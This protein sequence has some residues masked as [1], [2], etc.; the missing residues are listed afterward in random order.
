MMIKKINTNILLIHALFWVVYFCF[1]MYQLTPR[2]NDLGVLGKPKMMLLPPSVINEKPAHAEG[3][4]L[5]KPLHA[6]SFIINIIDVIIHVLMMMILAYGNYSFLLPAYLN[7]K[8]SRIDYF[9]KTFL[10]FVVCIFTLVSIKSLL[11]NEFLD[12]EKSLFF[13][14][15]FIIELSLSALFIVFFVSLLKFLENYVEVEKQKKDIENERLRNEL[16]LL[17]AQVNPHFLF[18]VFNNL[19]ALS[20]ENSKKTPQIIEK[21]AQIMRYTLYESNSENVALEKEVTLIENIIDL[22]QLHLGDATGRIIF[23]K[24]I[25]KEN[26]YKIAPMILITFLEN[27]FKHG[28]KGKATDINISLKIKD[29]TLIYNIINAKDDSFIKV[30]KSGIGLK[31]AQRQLEFFY[32]NQ[33]ILNVNESDANYEVTLT[34]KITSQTP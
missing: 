31:N 22:E 2:N 23:K 14:P 16:A 8:S 5:P 18:N 13:K 10:F 33:Y 32:P 20:L 25:D 30:E 3:L 26:T 27:A 19:Y 34:L 11:R 29:N 9:I 24:D 1:F 28:S 7:K 12:F 4:E 21:L 15:S 17:K 6:H